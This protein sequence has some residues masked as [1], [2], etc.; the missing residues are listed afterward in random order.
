MLRDQFS[1]FLSEDPRQKNTAAAFLFGF[2]L[3]LP[4]DGLKNTWDVS[5]QRAIQKAVGVYLKKIDPAAQG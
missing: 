1:P 5:E 3:S 4:E 2:S